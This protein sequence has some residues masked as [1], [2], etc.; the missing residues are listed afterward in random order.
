MGNYILYQT[1]KGEQSK[2]TNLERDI[3]NLLQKDARY[4]PDKLSAML[5]ATTDE[6]ISTIKK[7][8]A[9]GTIVKYTTVVNRSDDEGVEALIEVKVTPQ[10]A[11]G[12]DEIAGEICLHPQV[13]SVFLMSGGYDL[14]VLIEGKSLK[15]V[16]MFVSERLSTIDSVISTA[17]HFILKKYKIEGATVKESE[18]AKRLPIQP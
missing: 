1:D 4:A 17:T 16:A 6:V 13:K 10:R 9:E 15:E 18:E 8:E 3:L 5:N 11:Q 14:S 12:F 7:L 2:M